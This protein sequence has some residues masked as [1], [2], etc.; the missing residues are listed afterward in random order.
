MVA[1]VWLAVLVFL[2]IGLYIANKNTPKPKGCENIT[3]DCD[4]CK[5]VDCTHN[6]VHHEE[7]VK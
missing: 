6:P 3:A 5:L 2:Y 4:G 1:I 7:E